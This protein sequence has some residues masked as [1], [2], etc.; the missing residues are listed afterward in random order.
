MAGG[1]FDQGQ[2]EFITCFIVVGPVDQSVAAEDDA[3][4]AGVGGDGLLPSRRPKSKA[5][6]L[7]IDPEHVVPINLMRVSCSPV[8]AGGNADNRVGMGV[9]NMAVWYE[10]VE[11]R[12]DGTGARVQVE[13]TMRDTWTT[14]SSST[15]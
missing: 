9:I 3:D 2:R 11:G 15:G 13:D 14:I 4:D 8:A 12:V 1:F 6:A 5:G 7:P 10:G